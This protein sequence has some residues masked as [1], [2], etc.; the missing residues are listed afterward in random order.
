L[1]VTIESEDGADSTIVQAANPDDHVFE[2]RAG[3]VTISGFRIKGASGVDV[4]GIYLNWVVH[5]NIRENEV[6]NNQYGIS[7]FGPF[8]YTRTTSAI[9]GGMITQVPMPMETVLVILLT[10][11]NGI[12]TIIH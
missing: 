2:V 6:L 1:C 7:I 9:T 5:C 10:A 12:T 8:Q 3:Y 11:Y 4:A